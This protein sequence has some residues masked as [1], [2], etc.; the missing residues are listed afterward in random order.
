[1]HAKNGGKREKKRGDIYYYHERESILNRSGER[2]EQ[3]KRG[4]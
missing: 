2:G 3:R 1:M 4:A